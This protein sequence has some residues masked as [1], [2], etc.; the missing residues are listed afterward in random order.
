MDYF[1]NVFFC[2]FVLHVLNLNVLVLFIGSTLVFVFLFE[3][4]LTI[5]VR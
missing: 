1:F 5:I 2:S 4:V 3:E